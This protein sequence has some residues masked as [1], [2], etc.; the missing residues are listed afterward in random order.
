MRLL[1]KKHHPRVGTRKKDRYGLCRACGWP[2]KLR[3][4]ACHSWRCRED[5]QLR[6]APGRIGVYLS[7]CFP[8][9]LKRMPSEV[10]AR[11]RGEAPKELEPESQDPWDEP[12]PEWTP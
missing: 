1:P 9:C 5:I 7:R 10:A 8:R 4:H 12:D 6:K 2:T 11:V 3:C